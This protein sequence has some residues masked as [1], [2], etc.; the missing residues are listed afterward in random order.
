MASYWEESPA[1]FK[2][3]QSVPEGAVPSLMLKLDSADNMCSD[4]APQT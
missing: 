4:P 1:P 2:L 3:S